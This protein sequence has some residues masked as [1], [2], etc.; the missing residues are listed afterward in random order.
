MDDILTAILYQEPLVPPYQEGL[1]SPG[2][3]Y[4]ERFLAL[5]QNMDK[6]TA[7]SLTDSA[8]LFARE[9][10]AEGFRLGVRFGARL[11]RELTEAD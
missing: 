8:R 6:T 2:S 7:W 1:E 3:C 9:R 5:L 10:Y 4:E 11:L